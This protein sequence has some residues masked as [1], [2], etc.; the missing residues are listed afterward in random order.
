MTL[1]E[2]TEGKYAIHTGE[3]SYRD[4]LDWLYQ[5][6]FRWF[7]SKTLDDPFFE[8]NYR[9]MYGEQTCLHLLGQ[10]KLQYS[11][12]DFYQTEEYSIIEFDEIVNQTNHSFDDIDGLL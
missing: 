2:L 1:Q 9:A 3:S 12:I 4:C 10:K 11:S 5:Q 7:P 6:G 8:P